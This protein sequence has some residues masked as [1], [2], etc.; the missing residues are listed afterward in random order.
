VRVRPRA[1]ASIAICLAA[2]GSS[3]RA[4]RGDGDPASDV[5][6]SQTLF[7][8]Q[9]AGV[10]AVQQ[11]ELNADLRALQRAG[12]HLRVAMIASSADLGSVTEL[13]RRPQTYARFLGV[14]LSL[15]HPGPLLVVMPNGVGT[16]GLGGAAVAR[17]PALDGA[18]ADDLGG[19]ALAAIERLAAAS[20]HPLPAATARAPSSPAQSDTISWIV[21]AIGGALVLAAWI[22]S[23]RARPVRMG[24]TEIPSG[25]SRSG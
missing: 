14:E 2:I 19:S 11:A 4:A 17:R 20:G 7:L 8:A 12:Y 9:D 16:Y 21:F 5:L 13:W 15:I 3:A 24:K 23:L 10:T 18:R 6:A 25:P 22:V 1:L